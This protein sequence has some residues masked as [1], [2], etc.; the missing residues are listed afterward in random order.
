VFCDVDLTAW[1]LYTDTP[2]MP[3]M[4][5]IDREMQ[6]VFRGDGPADMTDAHV[7]VVGML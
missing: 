3:Q 6:V 2:A 4:V 7:R 1:G 5:L